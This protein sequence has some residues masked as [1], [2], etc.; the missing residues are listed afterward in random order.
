MEIWVVIAE[1]FKEQ[2][3][4]GTAATKDEAEALMHGH[5]G[6]TTGYLLERWEV[7]GKRVEVFA[8]TRKRQSR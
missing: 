8:Y 5:E 6:Y 2:E 3:V 7:G 4:I 1:F